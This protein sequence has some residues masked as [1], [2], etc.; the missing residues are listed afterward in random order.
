[1]RRQ[2]SRIT[3]KAARGGLARGKRWGNKK[4]PL[5]GGRGR[6]SYFSKGGEST[7]PRKEDK[8]QI[9]NLFAKKGKKHV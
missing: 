2:Y 1:V 8:V 7:R 9:A 5:E 6:R 3:L 4:P